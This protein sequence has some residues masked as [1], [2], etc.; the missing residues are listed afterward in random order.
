M[1]KVTTHPAH[2]Y[3]G[4]LRVLRRRSFTWARLVGLRAQTGG[5]VLLA[6]LM[7]RGYMTE[8]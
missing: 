3:A 7:G 6:Q 2:T 5:S 1:N 4:R 8:A